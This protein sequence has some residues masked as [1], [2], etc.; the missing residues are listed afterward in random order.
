MKCRA[1]LTLCALAVQASLASAQSPDEATFT[2]G[3]IRV[4][5]LQRVSE[6]TVYTYLPVNIGDALNPRRIREAIRDS[7][8][9]RVLS[10]RADA[11]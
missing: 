10:R 8:Q 2:V 4:E 11:P 1:V 7:L 6:G 9:D 3:N 5:G